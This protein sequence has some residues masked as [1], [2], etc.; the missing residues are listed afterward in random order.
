M[1]SGV[2]VSAAVTVLLAVLAAQV[3][4]GE[5][6]SVSVCLFVQYVMP[7]IRARLYLRKSLEIRQ[8]A[9]CPI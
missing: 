8:R 4:P 3:D 7:Y 1:M 2:R 6:W 5:L 9:A